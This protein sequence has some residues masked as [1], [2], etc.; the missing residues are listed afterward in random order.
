MTK[1]SDPN[2]LEVL[3]KLYVL[4]E[5]FDDAMTTARHA[6]EVARDVGDELRVKRI[7]KNLELYQQFSAE[8]QE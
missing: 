8:R 4:A 6:L 7:E 5:R 2:S 3:S 1:N